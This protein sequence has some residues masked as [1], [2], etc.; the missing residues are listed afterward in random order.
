MISKLVKSITTKK[1]KDS[2]PVH[3]HISCS[4]FLRESALESFYKNKFK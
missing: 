1:K 4:V 3:F 2:L